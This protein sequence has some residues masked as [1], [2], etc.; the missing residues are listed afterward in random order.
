MTCSIRKLSKKYFA[1][2]D[3]QKGSIAVEASLL[4]PVIF[5]ILFGTVQIIALFYDLS[6]VSNA[7]TEAARQGSLSSTSPLNNQGIASVV[8]SYFST[9]TPI[10]FT[11][12]NTPTT[13]VQICNASTSGST[14]TITPGSCT[15]LNQ[16]SAQTACPATR[17]TPPAANLLIVTVNYTFSGLFGKVS[18]IN[19]ILWDGKV[20]S[21][22]AQFVCG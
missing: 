3:Q 12:A 9:N 18:K 20:L 19:P 22:T 6:I 11:S 15:T 17:A 10:Y 8:T 21:S 4:I 14:F 13:V 16:S 1:L 7:A 2:K 5:L